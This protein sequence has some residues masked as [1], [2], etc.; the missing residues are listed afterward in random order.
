[1]LKTRH[2]VTHFIINLI[3]QS[4]INVKS[5]QSSVNSPIY[6]NVKEI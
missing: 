1:M 4:Q 3:I 6:Q 2:P 5:Y